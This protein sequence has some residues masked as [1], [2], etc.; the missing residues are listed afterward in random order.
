MSYDLTNLTKQISTNSIRES[1]QFR[2]LNGIIGIVDSASAS[3][4]SMLSLVIPEGTDAHLFDIRSDIG[5]AYPNT[6]ERNL[7][8]PRDL[9]YLFDIKKDYTLKLQSDITDHWTEENYVVNDHIAN[10]PILI[11]LTGQIGE[12]TLNEKTELSKKENKSELG[13]LMSNFSVKGAL[14]FTTSFVEKAGIIQM[15]APGVTDSV[16]AIKNTVAGAYGLVNRAQNIYKKF[17]KKEKEEDKKIASYDNFTDQ[18]KKQKKTVYDYFYTWWRN[19]VSFKIIT[20]YGVFHNMFIQD[21]TA[22][23]GEKTKYVTDISITFKKL[24][25]IQ[26]DRDSRQGSNTISNQL[27]KKAPQEIPPITQNPNAP[28]TPA[29]G[30]AAEAVP[31][32]VVDQTVNSSSSTEI[33]PT[34]YLNNVGLVPTKMQNLLP[35]SLGVL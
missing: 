30:A 6:R 22:N 24:N 13:N 33:T 2:D 20:P 15:F 34:G 1:N 17:S 10:K 35:M 4:D 11:T 31:K 8:S 28:I 26:S 19:K 23:Q 3:L 18:C 7:P 12:V 29:P 9:G 16:L 14:N 5:G 32:D 27:N 25:V 21:L